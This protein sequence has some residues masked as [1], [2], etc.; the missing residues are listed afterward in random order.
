[1]GMLIFGL[2]ESYTQA[3]IG[4]CIAGLLNG[5]I[6]VVK[7]FLTEIT[8]DSNRGAAFSYMSVAWALGT[9]LGPLIGG[10]LCRPAITYPNVFG[11]NLFFIEYP[12]FLPVLIYVVLAI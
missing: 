10:L 11:N 12:Y 5:N 8:D 4:R 9:I 6:G 2:S 3:V 1:M 7:S